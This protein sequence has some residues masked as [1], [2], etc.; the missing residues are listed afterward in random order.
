MT[1]VRIRNTI[2]G[3]VLH[4]KGIDEENNRRLREGNGRENVMNIGE[5]GIVGEGDFMRT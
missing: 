5:A 3:I 1:K 2:E 4:D